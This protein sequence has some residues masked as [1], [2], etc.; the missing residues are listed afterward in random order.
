MIKKDFL[1]SPILNMLSC[2][3]FA[4]NRLKKLFVLAI[5]IMS[6]CHIYTQFPKNLAIKLFFI[7]QVSTANVVSTSKKKSCQN[8]STWDLVLKLLSKQSQQR[9]RIIDRI[10]G[11][12]DKSF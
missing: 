2:H 9:K 6:R 5:L 10:N 8:M 7:R 12:R 4:R 3:I 1:W 11:L